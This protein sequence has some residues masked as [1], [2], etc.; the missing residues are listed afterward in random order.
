M[1]STIQLSLLLLTLVSFNLA[2]QTQTCETNVLKKAP[3]SR[4]IVNID[5]NGV[6]DGTVSD[7]QT[8]LMWAQC[9]QGLRGPLC[10]NG[11]LK[12]LN[13]SSALNETRAT[14]D[15]LE[16]NDWRLPNIKELQTLVERRCTFPAVNLMVFLNTSP[17]VFWSASP[18]TNDESSAWGVNFTFGSVTENGR[19]DGRN[20][21]LVRG[22]Q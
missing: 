6:P 16:R 12:T 14:S 10:G 4:F 2:A 11:D 22:G 7:R 13:W 1:K 9:A 19:S 3:A 21:R 20:V 8:G 17:V 15:R 5:S 18:V